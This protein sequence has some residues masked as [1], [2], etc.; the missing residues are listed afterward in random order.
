MIQ[1]KKEKKKILVANSVHTQHGKENSEKNSKKSQKIKKNSF[2]HYF[3]GKMRLDRPRK[4]KKKL[5]SQIR[6]ILDPGKKISK[7]IA[8]KFKNFKNLFPGLFLAKTG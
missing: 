8:K 6:L 1:A 2:W 4:G 3:F 5:Q 7:N